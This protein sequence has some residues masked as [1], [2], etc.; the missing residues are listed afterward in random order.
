[1]LDSLL[2]YTKVHFAREERLFSA[3]AY[4]DA[5]AHKATHAALV[6][7]IVDMQRRY[8]AGHDLEV[9]HDAMSSIM[10]WLLEHI[11]GTDKKYVPH[12]K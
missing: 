5:T 11:L 6:T 1:M 3:A 8:Q 10:T 4:P 12:L 7:R 9:S 2:T